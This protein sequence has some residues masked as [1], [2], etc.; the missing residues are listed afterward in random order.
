MQNAG[1]EGHVTSPSFG[2]SGIAS[3]QMSNMSTTFTRLT[4][5]QL[6]EQRPLSFSDVVLCQL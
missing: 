3:R 4:V 1:L 2:T 5:G 6:P